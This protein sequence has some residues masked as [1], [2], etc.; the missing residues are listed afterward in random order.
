MPQTKAE[1]EADYVCT[2]GKKQMDDL[3]EEA[4]DAR[5]FR[6]FAEGF[7]GC[8][9]EIQDRL[10]KALGLDVLLEDMIDECLKEI[11]ERN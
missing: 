11:A 1:C 3:N 7:V 6:M 8:S 10:V 5:V 4:K 9:P 2:K